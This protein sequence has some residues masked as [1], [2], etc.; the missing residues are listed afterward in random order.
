MPEGGVHSQ[1]VRSDSKEY[2]DIDTRDSDRQQNLQK[3]RH[4][5]T[6]GVN[7]HCAADNK[8]LD[9]LIKAQRTLVQRQSIA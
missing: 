2:Y 8:R 5:M 3:T 9:M 4:T 6:R 1:H 7:D